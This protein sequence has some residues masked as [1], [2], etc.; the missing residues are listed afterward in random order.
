[1]AKKPITKAQMAAHIAEKA[2]LTKKAANSILDEIAA[3]AYKEAKKNKEFTIPGLGKLV[4][5]RRKARKGR[6]PATG[7]VIK[8]PA[9]KVLKFR[10]AKACKDAVTG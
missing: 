4:V 8:I 7:Q 3:L 9:K 5:V 2:G 10:V 6:N 1:M